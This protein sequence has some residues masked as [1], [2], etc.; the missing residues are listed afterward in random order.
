VGISDDKWHTVQYIKRKKD[1]L[2]KVDNKQT[3]PVA[4]K[5]IGYSKMDYFDHSFLGEIAPSR[6]ES[7]IQIQDFIWETVWHETRVKKKVDAVNFVTGLYSTYGNHNGGFSVVPH[8]ILPTFNKKLPSSTPKTMASTPSQPYPHCTEG[9]CTTRGKIQ[10][11][12]LA[13]D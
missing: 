7:K 6:Y 3:D 8:N 10:W 11:M 4:I 13:I 9:R 12:I 5:K 1:F 2:L